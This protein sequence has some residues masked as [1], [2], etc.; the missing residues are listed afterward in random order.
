MAQPYIPRDLPV[1]NL[2]WSRLVNLVGK[3]NAEVARFDALLQTLR[4][5]MLLLRTMI[6]QEAVLSSRIEGTQATLD[7]VL[8]F[9]A[10]PDEGSPKFADIQEVIN[11]RKALQFGSENLDRISLSLRLLREMH[12]ILMN[13][14]RGKD[15][16][17]GNYRRVQNW[18]GPSGSVM[19]SATFVPPTPEKIIGH[20]G[21]LEKYIHTDDK[22]FL[23]QAAIVHAQFELIHP[24]LDGN[25]R[26][27]RILLATFLYF[28]KALSFPMFFQSAYFEM[29][30]EEY[31]RKLQEVSGSNDWEGWIE[32]FLTG[33][34]EQSKVNTG[35]VK[36]I[37]SLYEQKKERIAV[38]TRSQYSIRVLDYLFSKPVFRS[39][40][41]AAESRIPK[42]TAN[43]ILQQLEE[44][45]V[46]F[47]VSKGKGTAPSVYGFTKL[48]RLLKP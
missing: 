44:A 46:I 8:R 42:A 17:P 37:H 15:R 18:I 13:G 5:P 32:Y 19:A 26:L 41:F 4:N 34:A 2:D 47:F 36:S 20:L 12:K 14:V 21:N 35:K 38:V 1:E 39:S 27:G 29:H 6:T 11:Y 9:E 10:F 45:K 28:K 22:D 7:E 31:Y 23:V 40:D 25:G 30:R 48:I 3:A 33:V 24:F 16:D 43:R